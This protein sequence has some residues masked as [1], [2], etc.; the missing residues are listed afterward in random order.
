MLY[1][2]Q[3][4]NKVIQLHIYVYIYYFAYSLKI[5]VNNFY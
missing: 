5:L 4:Y 3:V 2:F 1:L